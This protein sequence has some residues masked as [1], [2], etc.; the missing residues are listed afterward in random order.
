MHH[1]A[2]NETCSNCHT[3]D[4]PGGT[5]NSSFCSNSACHGSVWEYAGFDA[6]ALREILADQLPPTPTP[7][8]VPSGGEL[9]FDATIGP[10]FEARCGSCHGPTGG[11]QGLDLTSYQ[12]VLDGGVDGP[13]VVPGEADSS[14]LVQKQTADQPHFSQLTPEELDLVIRWINAGAPE[15]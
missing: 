10:L 13:A 12:G 2:F 6:P 15:E 7:M 1:S 4:N 11:I 9:T 5:D 3:T 14:L 8:P